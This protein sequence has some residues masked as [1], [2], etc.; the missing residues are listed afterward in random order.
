MLMQSSIDSDELS[1]VLQAGDHVIL[2]DDI[3]VSECV[4]IQFLQSNGVFSLTPCCVD[5]ASVSVETLL[6]SPISRRLV[7]V[8]AAANA[9]AASLARAIAETGVATL[10]C[11]VSSGCDAGDFM[12]EDDS[13]AVAERL[14]QLGYI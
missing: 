9:E 10:C 7:V 8:S 14:R 3:H 1:E 13:E 6:N 4:D 11:S 5:A 12:D 2:V